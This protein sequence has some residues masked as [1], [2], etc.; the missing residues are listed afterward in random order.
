VAALDVFFGAIQALRGMEIEVYSGE[1]VCLIGANGA[2]KT[3][4]LRAITGLAKPRSGSILLEGREVVGWPTYRLARLG[5]AL[6][7][8]GRHLFP[9]LTVDE[10]LDLGAYLRADRQGVRRDIEQVKE[11]FPVLRERAKQLAGTLSGGEQ[12]MLAVARALMSRPKLLML[13][14]P[15]LGL[16]PKLVAQIF[17]VLADLKKRRMTILLVEQNARQALTVADRG[18]VLEAGRVIK[19]GPAG[20][21]A[22]DDVVRKAYLG[23]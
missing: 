2:G 17:Q 15:S 19:A 18:Y 3:T 20:V 1:L 5:L 23:G 6:C 11:D 9:N 8:E 16:A 12:Q 10:N 13:D 22:K 14:E 21:L 4:S 7:P